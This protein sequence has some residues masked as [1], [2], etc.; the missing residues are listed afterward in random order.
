MVGEMDVVGD[1]GAAVIKYFRSSLSVD[2]LPNC[3]KT[4]FVCFD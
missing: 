4:Y 3:V 2:I 1:V